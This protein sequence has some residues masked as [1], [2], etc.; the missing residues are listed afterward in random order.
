MRKHRIIIFIILVSIFMMLTLVGCR[1]SNSDTSQETTNTPG[2][3]NNP[4]QNKTETQ[5]K[6]TPYIS[7]SESK[8]FFING[9]LLGSHDNKGWHSLCDINGNYKRGAGNSEIFYAK[10]LLDIDAYYVYQGTEFLGLSKQIIWTTEETS[11]LGCFEDVEAPRKFAKYGQL[12]HYEGNSHTMDRIFELP[13]KL[14]EEL[15][16][17]EIPNYSF[18]TEFVYGEKWERDFSSYKLVTNSSEDMFPNKLINGVEPTSEGKKTLADLFK[19][20][21]MENTIPNFTNCMMGDFDNDSRD[22]YLMIANTPRDKSGWPL[23]IGEG[24]KDKVGTF[25]AILYQDDNGSVHTLQSDM[26][27][28]EGI[29]E[30]TNGCKEI[31][32][33]DNCHNIDLA[34]IADLNGDGNMEI[35]VLNNQWEGGY[36]LAFAQNARGTYE[37]VMRSNWGM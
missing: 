13:L 9:S 22:E 4:L 34:A 2:I 7:S 19:E 21:N 8:Y 16:S 20:N 33:I 3:D 6:T 32:D 25:S 14:G 24:K 5:S 29:T 36:T 35:I 11:G 27:P 37:V 30:F 31:I 17:L 10:D 26:R 1:N 23:I 18:N 15:S 28:M 12:Y